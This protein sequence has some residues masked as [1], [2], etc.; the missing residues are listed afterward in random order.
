MMSL[1]N[2]KQR[3]LILS[4]VN[5]S[6]SHPCALDIYNEAV[7]LIPNI[8]LGTVYRNLNRLVDEGLIKRI[9]TP[10]N[11]DRF[12]HTNKHAHFICMKCGSIIDLEEEYLFNLEKIDDNEVLDCEVSFKG[13]C[14]NCKKKGC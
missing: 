6:Y 11:I 4:I 8:S 7:K 3:D 1:R 2:T 12:D 13:I 10:D 9:K 5:N 14:K